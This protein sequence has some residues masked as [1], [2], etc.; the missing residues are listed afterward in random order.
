MP[1][2]SL[3]YCSNDRRATALLNDGSLKLVQF[4]EEQKN[5]CDTRSGE[6]LSG[7]LD[8]AA[9]TGRRHRTAS[10]RFGA[11]AEAL[12]SNRTTGH[13]QPS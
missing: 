8:E 7:D 5:K 2:G 13:Q 1:A 3:K 6:T 9:T 10:R 11:L 12:P 4:C